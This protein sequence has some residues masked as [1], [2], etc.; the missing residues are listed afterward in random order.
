ML[1]EVITQALKGHDA[2]YNIR[3]IEP[4]I[5]QVSQGDSV[6]HKIL[7]LSNGQVPKAVFLMSF[8]TKAVYGD[9][10]EA[11]FKCSL[12]EIQSCYLSLEDK[13]FPSVPY[14]ATE[15]EGMLR[16]YNDYKILCKRLLR[17]NFV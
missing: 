12:N 8:P 2:I 15:R 7:T 1:Y 10:L 4:S 13:Q 5:F 16:I 3:R 14:C 9:V 11:P 6:A 17:N